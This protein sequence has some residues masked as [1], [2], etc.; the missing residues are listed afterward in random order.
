VTTMHDDVP[1]PVPSYASLRYKENWFFILMSPREKVFGIFHFNTE[2]GFDRA[3]YFCEISVEGR[4][5]KYSNETTLPSPF[6]G[7]DSVGDDC[8]QVRFLEPHCLFHVSVKD[9]DFELSLEFR[10]RFPTFDY[11]ACKYANPDFMSGQEVLTLGTNL[12]YVH[13]QQALNV[14]GNVKLKNGVEV[15][16]EGR[17]YRDHSWGFRAD[18]IVAR[19]TWSNLHFS[20]FLVGVK[21]V[22]LKTREGI[23]SQEGYVVDKEGLCA[24]KAISVNLHY[25]DDH[26][27]IIE[28][29]EYRLVDVLGKSYVIRANISNKMEKLMLVSEKPGMSSYQMSENFCTCVLQ[30]TGEVGIAHV[31]IGGDH[32]VKAVCQ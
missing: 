21:T 9:S 28:Y 6:S 15:G 3:R 29:V 1:H 13:Q 7:A 31:E 8:M 30:E 11:T 27:A 20:D 26:K 25:F 10:E 22:E 5:Y 2:A 4:R 14:S 18:G 12:P 23:F 16:V 17:G 24:L 19:H 32:V